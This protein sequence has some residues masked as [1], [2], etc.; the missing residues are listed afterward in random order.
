MQALFSRFARSVTILV[1]AESLAV[2]MSQYLVDRIA[3]EPTIR[4]VTRAEVVAVHGTGSLDCVDVR[5]IDTGETKSLPS[6]AM[7]I[8]IG[9]APRTGMVAELLECDD[10]GFLL[11][12]PD[13]TTAGRAPRGWTLDRDP[14]LLECNVPGVFA[15]GDVRA[16][17]SKRVAAA[18]GEG[19]GVIGMVH[20]YLETV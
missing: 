20:R 4:V 11:T 6:A 3:T 1:R 17:S 15:V 2:S 19:S 16:G 13:L 10:K 8:F 18:V 9:A 5:N 12:G 14:Y 7:F